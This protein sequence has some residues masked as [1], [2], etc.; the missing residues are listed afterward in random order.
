MDCGGVAS[1]M[2]MPAYERFISHLGRRKEDAEVWEDWLVMRSLDSQIVEML[3]VDFL[4]V[5]LNAPDN[6]LP[7]RFADGRFTDEWGSIHKIVGDYAEM[8]EFPLAEADI[9]DIDS[10]SW[11]DPYDPGRARGAKD[12]AKDLYDNTD[13]ALATFDIGRLFEWCQWVRGMEQFMMDLVVN[14]KFAIALMDRVLEVQKGLT[15]VLLREVGQYIDVITLGDDLGA[16]DRL[17]LSPQL[18]REFI[19]P[20]HKTLCDYV[21]QRTDAKIYFH[22][23]GAVYPIIDDLIEVGVDILNPVQPLASGMDRERIKNTFGDKL[24]F[25]GGVDTQ[26][27]IR[28]NLEEVIEETRK[29]ITELGAG[30]GFILAPAHNFQSIDPPENILAVYETAK[31]YGQYPL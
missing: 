16:Q 20:R 13:Y 22:T 30:G 8:V 3:D 21:H 12:K 28:G 5:G 2:T 23:D 11:P 24:V 29:C 19:K 27:A 26:Q 14:Q 15:D 7:K 4:H 25:W 18:Y 1:T 31:K 6:W 10:Y 17:L 9:D